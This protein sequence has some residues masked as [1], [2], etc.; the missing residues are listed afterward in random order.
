MA[1]FDAVDLN[2]K[3]VF[4]SG[5]SGNAV[6]HSGKIVASAAANGD[7]FRLMR[8]PAG[9]RVDQVI[10][11]ND[12]LDTNGAPTAASKL[13]YTPVNASDGPAASDA[14]FAAAGQ[15][16]LQA[17]GVRLCNFDPIVFDFDVY[18]ILTM[19]AASATFAAGTIRATAIGENVGIK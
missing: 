5:P 16:W 2:S 3:N 14:Y 17:A 18:L 4:S 13:G 6:V 12:D 11:G 7:I 15:T 8:I 19:T 1:T 9:T 10:V